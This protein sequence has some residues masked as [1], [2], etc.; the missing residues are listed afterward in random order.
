MLVRASND[1]TRDSYGTIIPAEALMRDW[2][3]GFMAHRTISSQHG[4]KLRGIQGKPQIGMATRVDFAPQL[5]VEVR[6]DDPELIA[7]IER[8][9]ITGSSLEFV[10]LDQRTVQIDGKDA[11]LYTR[12]SSEPEHC[13]LS[14]VDI[15]SVPSADL[16][17]TRADATQPNWAFAVVDPAVLNGTVTDPAIIAQ[18]RW[19]LHHDPVTHSLDDA[20]VQTALRSLETIAVPAA[21]TLTAAQIRQRALEHLARHITVGGA[22]IRAKEVFVEIGKWI[23]MRVAQLVLEGKSEAEAK[24]TAVSEARAKFPELRT[25]IDAVETPAPAQPVAP[26]ATVVFRMESAA[27]AAPAPVVPARPAAPALPTAAEITATINAEIERRMAG[28]AEAQHAA[29]ANPGLT[30]AFGGRLTGD[31]LLA[32]IMTRT[33]IPQMRG[34][35]P[36]AEQLQEVSNI[37]TQNGINLRVNG[38]E[39]ATRALTIEGNGT[40]IYNELARQFVVKP[41]PDIIGRNHFMTVPMGGVNKRSFPRFDRAGITH[42]WNR[43]SS[44]G[45]G[46][47]TAITAATDPTLDF[48]DM[49]VTELNSSV[50]VPDSFQLFNAQ[51]TAFISSILLPAMRGA[52]QFEEDRQFFLST[53]THPN[54]RSFAG[55]KNRAGVTVIA[56]STNGDLFTQILLSS[57]LRAM[58]VNYRS[59]LTKLAFYVAV[60]RGDDY[61]DILAARQTAYGDASMA[62]FANQPGP[63]PISI[64]RGIPVYTVPHLPTNETQGSSTDCSTAYLVHRDIPVI[65]DALSLRIEP[66]RQA[67]FVDNLQL[68]EFVGLGYQF[69]D[70]LVRRAGIRPA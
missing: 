45:A 34:E 12:L 37:L 35:R 49:E 42:Q 4:L 2:L 26:A 62:R 60:A 30:R 27:P 70:A 52:A 1:T 15:P 56:A 47:T 31:A 43:S 25:Q 3:P 39:L 22:Q 51:G 24:A 69:P 21:A 29:G 18:L 55:F 6:L 36:S 40:V 48:F 44:V 68:Q 23:Q 53:G 16:L 38:A 14:L 33:V 11:V 19:F 57:L 10:P 54:P 5:E 67:G 9:E 66:F 17:S 7:A 46:S 61:G 32:E 65:G 41:Q 50:I 64:H 28:I 58:P 63:A 20:M 13:G 8:G 59:D